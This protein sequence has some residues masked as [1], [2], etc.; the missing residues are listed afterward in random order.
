MKELRNDAIDMSHQRFGS[1]VAIDRVR[2]EG[3]R[4]LFWNCKCDCGAKTVA[5]GGHLRAGRRVSCGCKSQDKIE[6]SGFKRLFSLYK[7][8]AHKR[9]KIFTLELKDFSRLVKQDCFYCG[10]E[11]KQ[12]IK[13]NKSIG[14]QIIYNGIDRKDS[15][16]GYEL[17][18]CVACCKRCNTSKTDMTFD[19]WMEHIKTI[20]KF[21]EVA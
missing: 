7:N 2:I 15:S 11:P 5:F 1:L 19:D 12:I 16:I 14:S 13:K 21:Q 18:N 8:K 4:G 17:F 20:I 10:L 3:K 6:E 9:N